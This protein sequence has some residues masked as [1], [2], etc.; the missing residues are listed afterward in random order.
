[1]RK[2]LVIAR[3]G[4]TSL[5]PQWLD[6]GSPRTWDLRLAPYQEV[7][8]E[9]RRGCDVGDVVVGPKWTGLRAVLNGWPGWR[10]YDYIWLPD[11]D[12]R[13]SQATINRMF[14]VAAGAG[15]DLFAP[16]LDDSSFFAHFDTM[17]NASFFGRYVG[18]VEIMVPG[19]SRPALERLLPTLDEGDTGWGWG[20]DSVW[21]KL[22]GYRNVGVLDAVTVSHTRPVGVLRDRDLHR[23]VHEESDRL[24]RAHDCRQEHV[25]FGAF[26][27][28]FQ[29]VDHTPEDLLKRLLEGWRHL[30]DRDP[31]IL[32]WI[33][34]FQRRHLPGPPYPTAGT[35]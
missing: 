9:A 19:F 3:V 6:H 12:I 14:H 30:I 28:S 33:G 31:R 32:W 15:L 25:T 10:D 21:P 23:R 2:N 7:P 29:R 34:E 17:R 4:A 5:H 26:D 8:D 22:L 24:L 11:D 1:M 27:E 13:T 16:A 18:F 20:L 35:P